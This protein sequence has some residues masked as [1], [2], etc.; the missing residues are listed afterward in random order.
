MKSK[1]DFYLSQS[2]FHSILFV[3]MKVVAPWLGTYD[4]NIC[5]TK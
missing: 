4:L 1:S 2:I 5:G 3:Q